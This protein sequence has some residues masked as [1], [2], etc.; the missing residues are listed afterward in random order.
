[1]S[2][3]TQMEP[4]QLLRCGDG[5]FE[6]SIKEMTLK[7][8]LDTISMLQKEMA[9]EQSSFNSLSSQLA[10]L[11]KNS[12]QYKQISKEMNASQTKLTMLMNRS[13][14][15]F[16]QQGNK[17]AKSQA[18]LPPGVQRHNS[19]VEP[20]DNSAATS[21]QRRHSSKVSATEGET[22]KGGFDTKVST[23]NSGQKKP[24]ILKPIVNNSKAPGMGD[25]SSKDSTSNGVS[26]SG[27]ESTS[28]STG[29]VKSDTRPTHSV[30]TTSTASAP[31]SSLTNG[32]SLVKPVKASGVNSA[33]TTTSSNSTDDSE[34]KTSVFNIGV[35]NTI[36]NLERRSVVNVTQVVT[37][38]TAAKSTTSNS[39]KIVVKPS[40]VQEKTVMSVSSNST[41]TAASNVVTTTTKMVTKTVAQ[42]AKSV[43]VTNTTPAT[44]ITKTDAKPVSSGPTKPATSNVQEPSQ[45]AQNIPQAPAAPVIKKVS[46]PS[47]YSRPPINEPVDPREQML[48]EIRNFKRPADA[49][50]VEPFKK[51]QATEVKL[52]LAQSKPVQPQKVEPA[53][54]TQQKIVPVTQQKVV[55]MTVQQQKTA[56]FSIPQQQ[57]A[58]PPSSEKQQTITSVSM[59]TVATEKSK[60]PE[61]KDQDVVTQD[62][63]SSEDQIFRAEPI[64]VSANKIIEDTPKIIQPSD[65]ATEDKVPQSDKPALPKIETSTE[66]EAESEEERP[67]EKFVSSVSFTH[68]PLKSAEIVKP[69]TKA[70][71]PAGSG[72]PVSAAEPMPEQG[73]LCGVTQVVFSDRHTSMIPD[74]IQ[75]YDS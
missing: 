3:G 74:Q 12:R 28:V 36:K 56:P 37:N 57:N 53:T 11:N 33:N 7:N 39:S 47:K 15:C 30:A 2:G 32:T 45:P 16:Q 14:K 49:P 25:T 6:K 9:R 43:T 61:K 5:E 18:P 60:E 63:K 51:A 46:Q 50:K 68:K 41:K 65:T 64:Q 70:P 52:D 8:L 55:S 48:K 1:M 19:N 29:S 17:H 38:G 22:I 4:G 62:S 72:D 69:K 44:T 66:D 21:V 10:S 59:K 31:V 42:P 26:D 40:N 34:N 13:M 75:S 67:E 71:S 20:K 54:P 24:V 27:T 58:V 35:R 23:Q 73:K